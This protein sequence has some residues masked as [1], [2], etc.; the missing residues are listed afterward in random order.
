LNPYTFHI[1][2]F[3]LAA[4]G[5]IFIGLAFGL[6]LGLTKSSNRSAN[7]F[8]SLALVFMV[9]AMASLLGADLSKTQCFH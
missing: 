3:D 2:L 5:T 1:N 7:G 4:L 6:Q 8:L 9:L